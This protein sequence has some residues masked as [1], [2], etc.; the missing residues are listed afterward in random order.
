[1]GYYDNPQIDSASKHSE[2]SEHA[3]RTYINQK[4]GFICRTLSPDKGCDFLAELITS[5][6]ATSWHVGIQ[7]KSI[8][9]P[10]IIEGGTKISYPFCT[11]RLGYLM[12]QIP[13]G[14]LIVIYDASTE[15]CYFEFVE[16]IV[17]ALYIEKGTVWENQGKVSIKIPIENCLDASTVTQ[18]RGHF[19]TLFR[20]SSQMQDSFGHLYGLPKSGQKKDDGQI[21]F[22]NPL[23]VERFLEKQGINLLIDY[24]IHLVAGLLLKLTERQI[25]DNT[26]IL[27]LSAVVNCELGH[28]DLSELQSNKA[29]KK[30]DITSDERVLVRYSRT[31]ALHKFQKL[32]LPEVIEQMESIRKEVLTEQSTLTLDINLLFFKLAKITF[33]DEVG[34]HYQQ[35]IFSLYQRIDAAELSPKVKFLFTLWN[36][37][38]YSSYINAVFLRD[39]TLLALSQQAQDVAP[40]FKRLTELNIKFLKIVEGFHTMQET[41]ENVLVRAYALQVWLHHLLHINISILN[42]RPEANG[43][44]GFEGNLQQLINRGLTAYNYFGE[45]AHFVEA[46]NTLCYVLEFL[47]I[48]RLLLKKDFYHDIKSLYDIKEAMEGETSIAAYAL[49][50]PKVVNRTVNASSATVIKNFTK[51]QMEAIGKMLAA[52]RNLTPE[53]MINAY[54]EVQAYQ[55]FY[56][57]CSNSNIELFSVYGFAGENLRYAIPVKYFLKNKIIDLITEPSSNISDLLSNWGF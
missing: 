9:T 45:M 55:Q 32:S 15:K 39:A 38:N 52:A 34:D 14:G 25:F 10:S 24:D 50:V 31:K 42:I 2:E 26:R 22:N 35:E 53:Q 7:L 54:T 11:S 41:D 29:L 40:L 13:A 47:E 27:S 6:L 18:I 4:S 49:Q 43:F 20:K 36:S 44:A 12:R 46:Y 56:Q 21:D 30:R 48:G 5:D 19:E 37:N 1:M 23:E 33:G 16:T 8:L 28:F 17:K 3:L 51:E 57:R